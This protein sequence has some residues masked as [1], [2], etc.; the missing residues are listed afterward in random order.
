[1]RI[2][3]VICSVPLFILGCAQ[4]QLPSVPPDHP[5]SP[6]A[7]EASAP[8]Y[9]GS[10]HIGEED[11]VKPPAPMPLPEKENHDHGQ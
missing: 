8:V 7:E 9:P 4:L 5:A 10:L 3:L 11:R 6:H 1:M 2:Y